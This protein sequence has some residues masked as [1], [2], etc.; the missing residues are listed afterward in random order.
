MRILDRVAG[1]L[2][3]LI[4]GSLVVFFGLATWLNLREQERATTKILTLNGAQIAALVTA[5]TREGMLRNDRTA[6]LNAV[7]SLSRQRD[8]ER[9]RIL[10][11]EGRIIYS[12]QGAEIGTTLDRR[13]EQCLTCHQLEEP[14]TWLPEAKMVRRVEHEGR[15]TLG[16][17]QVIRNES[18]CSTAACHAHPPQQRLLGV[19]DI[20]M[21][22]EPYE[23]ARTASARQLELTSLLAILVVSLVTAVSVQRMVHRPVRELIQGAQALAQGDH[24]ARVPQMNRDELGVLAG[25]FNQMA[26]DLEKAHS[27]LLEWAQ[28]LEQRVEQKTLELQ[29]A[30]EQILQVEKMASLGRLAAVVAHEI[31][32]PLSSVVTYARILDRELRDPAAAAASPERLRYLEAIASEA[33]R[34]GEIVSHL[35]AFARQRGG[36]FSAVDFNSVVEKA[37]FLVRHKLELAEV[38]TRLELDPKLGSVEVDAQQIQQAL[39]ALIINACE[40]MEGGGGTLTLRTRTLAEGLAVEVADSGPGMAPE[41]AAHAFEPFFSTKSDGSGVGLGLA[42]VYSIV[43]RHGGGIELETKPGAGCRFTITLPARAP[44]GGGEVEV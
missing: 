16:V 42:V 44:D 35:L 41:V 22:L 20:H 36:S 15:A 17:T 8:I 19:L 14:P 38:S 24:S 31:N 40:A 23:Q 33:A 43:K 11:K 9:I 32:N 6:I 12:S 30:Q 3:V 18:D 5:A 21:Q 26:H 39:M 1:K 4:V 7:H 10:D 2:V 25:A 27:E 37:V 13:A 28:T 29:H 34:C